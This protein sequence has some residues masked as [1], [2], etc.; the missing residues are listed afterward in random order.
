MQEH[1]VAPRDR[2]AK[3]LRGALV[4]LCLWAAVATS[5]TAQVLDEATFAGWRDHIQPRE[6]DE[7]AFREIA[8]EPSLWS[9]VVQA[10]KLGKPILLWAMN[11]HPLGCT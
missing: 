3:R 1:E 6:A 9:G 11:G 5:L 10:Q 2:L 7:V 8:W 4:C